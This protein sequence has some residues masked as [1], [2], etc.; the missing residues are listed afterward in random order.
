MPLGLRNAATVTSVSRTILPTYRNIAGDI[1]WPGPLH[2]LASRQLS[3]NATFESGYSNGAEAD[4]LK[5]GGRGFF[6]APT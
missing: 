4:A 1:R 5:C 2:S 6:G 3:E